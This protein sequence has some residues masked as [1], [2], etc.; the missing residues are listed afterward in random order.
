MPNKKES[1]QVLISLHMP[2]TVVDALDELARKGIV[3]SRSEAIRQAVIEYIA[4]YTCTFTTLSKTFKAERPVGE[5][6]AFYSMLLKGR[7]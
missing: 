4:K 6:E 5:E 7:I 2:K 3:P 1:N